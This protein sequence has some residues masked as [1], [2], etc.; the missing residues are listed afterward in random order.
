MPLPV[1]FPN[2]E[3]DDEGAAPKPSGND[4]SGD[5]REKDKENSAI[6]KDDVPLSPLL[7]PDLLENSGSSGSDDGAN[8]SK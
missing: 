7:T 1:I 2:D 3:S 4:S 6:D 8:H 5:P